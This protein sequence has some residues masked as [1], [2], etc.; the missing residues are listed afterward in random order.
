MSMRAETG[1]QADAEMLAVWA[2]EVGFG[3]AALC[4][5]E[6]FIAERDAVARGPEIAERRQLRFFPSEE[7]PWVRSLAVML[8]PY[9]P[10]ALSGGNAV[11]V[12]SYY[13]A[14][15][16]A[17]HAAR[18]LENRLLEKGV[19]A[20]TNVSFPAREAAVRAG[21]GVIGKNG[22]LIHPCFGTRT[23]IILMA[24]DIPAPVERPEG[25]KSA[26][27][28]AC[29]RCA[30]ACPAKA[31]DARGMSHPERCIRN[32]MMEGVVVPE[33]LRPKMGMRLLGCDICQRVCPM[34]PQTPQRA[35]LGLELDDFLTADDAAFSAGV[36]RLAQE[37]GKN[38]ARPQRV[39]AQA[40]LLA[41]NRRREEDLPALRAWAQLPFEAVRVHAQWAIRQ[42]EQKYVGKANGSCD[43]LDPIGKTD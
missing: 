10:C 41:G 32:F 2:R 5:A 8:W 14:S 35:G 11:F 6:D 25:G 28:A 42:I 16:A 15:N 33:A 31:I 17:Y 29:G 3:E 18:E 22:M 30:A 1:R 39:R 23:V 4:G 34:Q 36:R 9:A 20:K 27:C 37:I 38:A 12:D 26:S 24:T 19:R 7:C 21:L 43:G 40:A 13:S